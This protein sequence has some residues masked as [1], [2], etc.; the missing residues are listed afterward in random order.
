MSS[1]APC[2]GFTLLELLIA[3]SAS[4]VLVVGMSSSIYIALRAA[5]TSTTPADSILEGTRT[6]TEVALDL[7]DTLSLSTAGTRNLFA[8]VPDRYGDGS[9][10]TVQYDWSGSAGDPLYRSYNGNTP[11]IIV[12]DV[13]E[14]AFGYQVSDAGHLVIDVQIQVSNNSAAAVQTAIFLENM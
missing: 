14:F 12:D 10:D 5:D 11:K 1:Q 7:Q 6:L 2:R 9:V 4:G 3:V 8:N 13:H